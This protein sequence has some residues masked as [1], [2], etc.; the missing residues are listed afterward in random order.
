[1]VQTL[2]SMRKNANETYPIIEKTRISVLA[3]LC[4]LKASV[5]R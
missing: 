1:M 2:Y 5:L 4:G 3:I